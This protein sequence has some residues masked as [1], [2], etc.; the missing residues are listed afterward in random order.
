MDVQIL[1]ADWFLIGEIW[2][3]ESLASQTWELLSQLPA[4]LLVGIGAVQSD[5]INFAY[6]GGEFI[7]STEQCF[8]SAAFGNGVRQ[9]SCKFPC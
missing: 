5:A 9:G 8:F 2:Y 4:L 6:N 3:Q 7:T 1:D